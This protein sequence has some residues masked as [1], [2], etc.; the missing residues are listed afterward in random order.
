MKIT[1]TIGKKIKE[2]L[3]ETIT[4]GVY[5][6]CYFLFIVFLLMTKVVGLYICGLLMLLLLP[7]M[8]IQPLVS[9]RRIAPFEWA[10]I[11]VSFVSFI[12]IA[13]IY[14]STIP[15]NNL[16]TTILT[17]T[18]SSLSGFLTLFG[19]GLT[20][21]HARL[22]K[23]DD[24]LK[25]LKPNIFPIAETTWNGLEK[26][27]R[28]LIPFDVS[29]EHSELKRAKKSKGSY[30]LKYLL[31]ANSDV[32]LSVLYG[33][34][35]NGKIIKS[36]YESVL[37]KN[38]FYCFVIDYKFVLK[39]KLNDISLILEDMLHNTYVAKMNYETDSKS[40]DGST[41]I[42]IKSVL[43]ITPYNE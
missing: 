29:E 19:V 6:V 14:I 34:L 3:F 10:T 41:E 18:A 20:V 39:E 26:E 7:L 27:K 43:D 25:S 23:K 8:I 37:L 30:Y 4:L 33:I 12:V 21:K 17:L 15:D 22:D 36:R 11:I 16:R 24:E 38:S 32:S 5:A 35:I 9:S 42:M 13:S 40:T 1:K 2:N 28:N 31:I